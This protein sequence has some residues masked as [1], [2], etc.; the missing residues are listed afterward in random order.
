M[1]FSRMRTA[2]SLQYR[3]SLS[4]GGLPDRPP[5]TE[6]PI[7]DRDRDPPVNRMTHR[8]KTLPPATSFA[9]GNKHETMT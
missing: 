9:G 4:G 7:L 1:H 2:R 5:G 6:T 3:G 8:G